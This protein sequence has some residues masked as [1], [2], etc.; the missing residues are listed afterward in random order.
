MRPPFSFCRSRSLSTQVLT[1]ELF[2]E[3]T[4]YPA[5]LKDLTKCQS[6]VIIES[7]FLT[8][9]RVSMILPT[10]ISLKSRDTKII[11][12]TRDPLGQEGY[13]R[14]EAERSIELLQDAGITIFVTGGH[15]RKLVILDRT[16]LYEGSLNV[17][18]QNDSCE[19]MRRIESMHLASQMIEF[20]GL[21]R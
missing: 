8:T 6:E 3:R 1:S 10:L 7:P 13:M 15:H 21:D 19:V 17:L 11:V 5:L 18:S 12:N 20:V 2:N 9:R 16:I 4:F 14:L